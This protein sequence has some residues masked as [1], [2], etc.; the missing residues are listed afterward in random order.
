MVFTEALAHPRP[1]TTART[2]RALI[3]DGARTGQRVLRITVTG[4]AAVVLEPLPQPAH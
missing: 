1:A 2:R 3:A 4:G